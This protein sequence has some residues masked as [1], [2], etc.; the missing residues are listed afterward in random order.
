M[1]RILVGVC[2]CHRCEAFRPG[3]RLEEAIRNRGNYFR[4]FE[5]V[6]G[7]MLR[8]SGA[9]APAFCRPTQDSRSPLCSSSSLVSVEFLSLL[10]FLGLFNF[11]GSLSR[12][13]EK[14]PFNKQKP[15]WYQAN[16]VSMFIGVAW[17]PP[18][19]ALPLSK[20]EAGAGT[21]RQLRSGLRGP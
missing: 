7:Q 18:K 14:I 3:Q 6:T 9:T 15:L 5:R 1:V 17:R 4:V 10:L 16:S 13:P 2:A 19:K 8:Q 12:A 11:P 21:Q 20:T